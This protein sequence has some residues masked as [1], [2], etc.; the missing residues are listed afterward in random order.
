M[1]RPTIGSP[2]PTRPPMRTLRPA[3]SAS[4]LVLSPAAAQGAGGP[5]DAALAQA[6]E[7]AAAGQ[8]DKAAAAFREIA[9]GNAETNAGRAAARLY[10][11]ALNEI[12]SRSTPPRPA[13][14][15]E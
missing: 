13:A 11:E 3:L 9:L 10:V 14:Y 12:G 4:P 5:E 7:H 8:W 1:G 15:E 6:R 2:M